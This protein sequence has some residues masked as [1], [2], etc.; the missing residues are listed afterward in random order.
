GQAE[1]R[2]DDERREGG[3]DA[4]DDRTPLDPV[5]GADRV[6]LV[7]GEGVH[8]VPADGCPDVLGGRGGGV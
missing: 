7:L 8:H 6:G 2:Q 5:L 1:Q 4:S 3:Q